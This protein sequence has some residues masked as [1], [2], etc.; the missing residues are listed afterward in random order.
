MSNTVIKIENLS[1]Q[2]RIGELHRETML[3]ERLV[4]L[5][6]HPLLKKSKETIW[7]LKDVSFELTPVSAP[8]SKDMISS[9]K[10]AKILEGYRGDPG[11][12]LNK[13]QNIIQRVSQLVSDFPE[14]SEMDINPLAAF[15]KDIVAVDARMTINI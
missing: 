10:A 3:R 8:E 9:I 2:Y 4:N 11:T 13:L 12:D 6:K 14:I 1:K 15:E 5:I 7:A